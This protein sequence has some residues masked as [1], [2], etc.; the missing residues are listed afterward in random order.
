MNYRFVAVSDQPEMAP[1][2]ADWLLDAFRHD[3]SPSHDELI[4]KLLAQSHCI[5]G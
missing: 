5:G 2:V 4:A 1:A 3:L